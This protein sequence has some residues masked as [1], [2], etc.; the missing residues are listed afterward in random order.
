MAISCQLTS[1]LTKDITCQYVLQSVKGIYLANTND[2]ESDANG[3]VTLKADAQWYYFEVAKNTAS[4]T[5]VL[6]VTDSGSKYRTH[7]LSFSLVGGYN[8]EVQPILD[9]LSLGSFLGIAV[10]ADGTGVLLG[11]KNSGL[12][13]SVVTNTGAASATEASGVS[14]E[15]SSD[16]TNS[17]YH[18]ENV[19]NFVKGTNA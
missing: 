11:T 3:E 7:T 9:T 12:E 15:M 17:A 10:F 6:N 14:V 13:A 16:L 19:D 1:G 4:F 8:D 2:V 5:D 18:I